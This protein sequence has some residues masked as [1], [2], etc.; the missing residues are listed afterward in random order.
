MPQDVNSSA[1][2]FSISKQQPK[3]SEQNQAQWLRTP[4]PVKRVFDKFPLAT[5]QSD[6]LPQ[7][8]TSSLRKHV[9]CVFTTTSD[10][11]KGRPSYNPGCL[12]W[13]V[14]FPHTECAI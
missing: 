3:L 12:K 1:V 2:D 6:E 7:G 13:Q 4:R 5:Y 9:L 8:R 10:S 11:E 14:R